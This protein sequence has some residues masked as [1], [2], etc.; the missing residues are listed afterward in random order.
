MTKRFRLNQVELK[1]EWLDA[2]GHLNEAFYLV[3][4]SETT[5]LLQDK[6]NIGVSWF[7]QT[8][9]A[10][11]TVETHIRYLREVRSPALL[12]IESVVLGSDHKRFW[13]AHEMIVDGKVRATAEFMTLHYSTR[14]QSTVAFPDD[15]QRL[16]KESEVD[17]KPEWASSKILL[18]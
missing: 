1:N 16:L 18:P 5:W 10:I 7:D 17:E 6:F 11:Y 4:M 8:G 15:V 9:C 3:P 14:D 12:E 2:Y 13:F